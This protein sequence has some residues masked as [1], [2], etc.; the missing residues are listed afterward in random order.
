MVRT[1]HHNM[2]GRLH[3]ITS[4]ETLQQLCR[5]RGAFVDILVIAR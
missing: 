2:T 3:F 5:L 1:Y 4:A